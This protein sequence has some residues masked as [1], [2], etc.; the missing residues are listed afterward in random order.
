MANATTTAANPLTD[1]TTAVDPLVGKQTS[2]ESSLSSWAGP[3]VTEMLGRGWALADMPYTAYTGQLTA[4]PSQLQ[5]QAFQGLAGLTMPT[6]FQ[7]GTQTTE[8]ALSGLTGAQTGTFTAPGVAQQY[9]SP[10]IQ[11]ALEPQI[12][13]ARRQAD[14]TRAQNAARLTKAGAYGGGRQAIMESEGQRNLLRNL[15]DITGRGYQT[16]YEQ[17]A[18]LYGS[19]QDRLLR[20]LQQQAG[21]GAQ[22]GTL[23]AA[24]QAAGL[25]GLEAQLGGGAIERDIE[26]QGLAADLAQFREE[27]DF[28]Y[29]QV[30]YMQSLLQELPLATQSYSYAQPS[31]LS[32]ILGSAGG[33]TSLYNSLFGK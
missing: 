28:P 10:Y 29:K 25:K 31:T 17:G 33:I 4:G 1:I 7:Q 16:A 12:A 8:Q 26:Q 27:R 6:Q 32:Q 2:T 23:G 13:E 30:Q 15:A 24:E 19:E 21:I 22:F 18:Q 14:I 9:M 20:N 3:Y 11:A 5:S